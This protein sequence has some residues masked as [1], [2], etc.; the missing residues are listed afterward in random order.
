MSAHYSL[1]N[2]DS[3][4]IAVSSKRWLKAKVDHD[5]VH[6]SIKCSHKVGSMP[7]LSTDISHV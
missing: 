7:P 2:G 3:K 5:F 6:F 4:E 1:V